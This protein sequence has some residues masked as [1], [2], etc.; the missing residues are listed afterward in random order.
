MNVISA[1]RK[2]AKMNSMMIIANKK[3]MMMAMKTMKTS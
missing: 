1:M 2:T 3:M